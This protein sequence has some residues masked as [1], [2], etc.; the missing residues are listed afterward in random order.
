MIMNEKVMGHEGL[1]VMNDNGDRV[2]DMC[3]VNNNLVIGGSI[4]PHERYDIINHSAQNGK[5][6]GADDTPAE[7]LKVDIDIERCFIRSS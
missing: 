7:A 2:A 4:F 1:G 3:A 5:A 6:T